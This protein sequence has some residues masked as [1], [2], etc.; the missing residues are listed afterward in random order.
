MAAAPALVACPYCRAPASGRFCSDC[1]KPLD[2]HNSEHALARDLLG[3]RLQNFGSLA[4]TAWLAIAEPH[5]LSRR[6]CAGDRHKLSSPVVLLSVTGALAAA[7]SV[8]VS[9]W[10]GNHAAAQ[11]DAAALGN[12]L[13]AVPFLKRWF[14]AAA[15]A[16]SA[17][18]SQFG[19]RL[20]QVGSWLAAAWP[21]LFLIPGVLVLAPWRRISRHDALI[22]A[23]VETVTIMTLAGVLAVI[24]IA[25]PG[26]ASSPLLTTAIW[27]LLCAHSARHI[28]RIVPGASLG[29]AVTRP[30]LATLLF[31]IIIYAWMTGVAALTLAL[32]PVLNA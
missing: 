16:A 32:A 13:D 6:W 22:V 24:R 4:R 5:T 10:T 26:V 28:R 31:P 17:D 21:M 8:F 11:A 3:L 12:V 7:I 14:P 9:G 29:Y 20:R 18:P 23:C 2:V 15:A 1:G 25:A 30:I 27:L 19:E